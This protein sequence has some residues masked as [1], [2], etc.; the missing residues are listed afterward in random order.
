MLGHVL[1]MGKYV[2]GGG[3]MSYN[4]SRSRQNL[5]TA[6]PGYTRMADARVAFIL[7]LSVC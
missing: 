5:G 6:C 3:Q 7:L 2:R 1:W 4:R